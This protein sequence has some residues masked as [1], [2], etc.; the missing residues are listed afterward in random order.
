[1][2][3]PDALGRPISMMFAG[4]AGQGRDQ[5]AELISDVGFEPVYVGPIRYARNLE[6]CWQ[7]A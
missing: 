2:K 5:V 7:Y 3:Q 4:P 6:V 1:M